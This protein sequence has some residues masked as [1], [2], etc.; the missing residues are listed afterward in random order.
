MEDSAKGGVKVKSIRLFLASKP[1]NWIVWQFPPHPGGGL[2]EFGE[3]SGKNPT[4]QILKN[5]LRAIIQC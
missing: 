1:T 5:R 2:P 3:C 4:E